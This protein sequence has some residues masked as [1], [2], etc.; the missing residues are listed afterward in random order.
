MSNLRLWPRRPSESVE[1]ERHRRAFGLTSPALE[2]REKPAR[3]LELRR[4]QYPLVTPAR[5][6]AIASPAAEVAGGHGRVLIRR[7]R[8]PVRTN[9]A[10]PSAAAAASLGLLGLRDPAP[11][12]GA[13]VQL[14]RRRRRGG[15]R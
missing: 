12:S 9:R 3:A 14:R 13:G 10:A 11:S 15:P 4:G 6:P 8:R 5:G 1:N 7:E 2:S